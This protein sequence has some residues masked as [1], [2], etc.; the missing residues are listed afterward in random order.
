MAKTITEEKDFVKLNNY[1]FFL[2]FLS[3]VAFVLLLQICE[4]LVLQL[5]GL[6]GSY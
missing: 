4:N 2:I 3:P 6:F 5:S 1:K